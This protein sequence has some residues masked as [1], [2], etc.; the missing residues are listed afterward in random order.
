MAWISEKLYGRTPDRADAA[1][2]AATEVIARS[3]SLR[4]QLEPFQRERDPFAAIT[5]W[6][7][8]SEDINAKQSDGALR[9]PFH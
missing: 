6:H 5:A 2:S 7:E 3:R 8:V 4:Q 9:G 1:L